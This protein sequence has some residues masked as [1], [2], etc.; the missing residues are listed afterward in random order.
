MLLQLFDLYERA[1]KPIE[2]AIRDKCIFRKNRYD[3]CVAYGD[4]NARM[5]LAI[6]PV[7]SKNSPKE[8][9]W[10]RQSLEA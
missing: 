4:R 9:F 5:P 8:S 2:R 3:I 1:S 10:Y 7:K 6:P